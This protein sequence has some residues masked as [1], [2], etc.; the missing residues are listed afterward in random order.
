MNIEDFVTYEQALVL[1]R[2]GFKEPCLYYYFN[3]TLF[4][5]DVYAHRIDRNSFRRRYS[6]DALNKTRNVSKEPKVCD[7]PTLAQVQK[8]LREKEV[9]LFISLE[10]DSSEKSKFYWYINDINGF[11]PDDLLPNN[12]F[13]TYEEALSAGITECLKRLE[14]MKVFVVMRFEDD[15]EAYTTPQID[16]IFSSEKEAL[17]RI[18]Y[19][20]DRMLGFY[21]DAKVTKLKSGYKIKAKEKEEILFFRYYLEVMEIEVPSDKIFPIIIEDEK[22]DYRVDSLLTTEEKANE[23]IN[24]L[25]NKIAEGKNIEIVERPN[26]YISIYGNSFITA[27]YIDGSFYVYD[28]F[29]ESI[30]EDRFYGII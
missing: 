17:R 26:G 14:K 6:V 19:L 18:E 29:E 28:L 9:F 7:A 4:S 23:R 15:I 20:K 24:Y 1:K 10:V 16:N 8:W 5:N 12:S 3:Y 25:K 30:E 21:N 11:I 27:L 2:L 22:S 13:N